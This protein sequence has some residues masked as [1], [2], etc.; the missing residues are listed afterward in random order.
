[1]GAM[2]FL[3]KKQK[4]LIVGFGF[5]V[6]DVGEGTGKLSERKSNSMIGYLISE[7]RR[8]RLKLYLVYFFN[9]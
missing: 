4:K 5:V 2:G 6:D 3:N 8:V 1:M 9:I 7:A